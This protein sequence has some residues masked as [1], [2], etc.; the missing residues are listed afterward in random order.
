M[1]FY[2]KNTLIFFFAV[3][4]ILFAVAGLFLYNQKSQDLSNVSD[5][6]IISL[7]QK[8]SDAGDYIK[9]HPDFKIQDKIILTKE[10][11]AAGQNAQNFKE[12]YQGLELQNNR[13]MK[14]DLI[15]S[16]G[17]NGLIAVIDFKTETTPKAYGLILLKANGQTTSQTTNK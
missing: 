12:V 5:S 8:N 13:Y 17:D 10:S 16:A 11:I 4:I 3:L 14:V 1:F 9:N 15:N 7:L 2:K 6:Q